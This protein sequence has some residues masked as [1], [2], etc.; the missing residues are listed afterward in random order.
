MTC[1]NIVLYIIR[2]Y[3]F[4]GLFHIHHVR[5]NELQIKADAFK[6]KIKKKN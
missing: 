3:H 1:D 6:F 2:I 5:N 4:R